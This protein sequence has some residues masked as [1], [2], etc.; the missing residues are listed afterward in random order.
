MRVR[1]SPGIPNY[2]L[3]VLLSPD[4]V[5]TDSLF[6]LSGQFKFWEFHVEQE[7]CD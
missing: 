2:F 1:V 4:I 7:R 6:I 3:L 5:I